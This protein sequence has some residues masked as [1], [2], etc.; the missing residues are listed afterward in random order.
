MRFD[1]LLQTLLPHH[2]R[3]FDKFE[4]SARNIARA[5]DELLVLPNAPRDQWPRIVD[6]I[7][8]Y[9]HQG[10]SITHKIFIELRGTFVTPFDAEDIHTL[11]SAL[12]DILDNIDGS[13]R[14]LVLYKIDACPPDM[15]RLMRSL[16][17]S[18][19]EVENGVHLLRK[20]NKPEEMRRIINRISVL[21][22]EADEI[23]ARSVADLF[24]MQTDPV[25]IIKLKEIYVSL[26]TATDMCDDAADVL[27]AILIKH[28]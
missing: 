13:A 2:E 15:I 27:E 18:V 1:R 25:E 5:A 4:E 21:E 12:D 10:D 24:E 16:R 28:A 7:K 11:A 9:E 23:F 26:E 3:F 6:E 17:D 8:N 20:L 14:R 19:K 22:H